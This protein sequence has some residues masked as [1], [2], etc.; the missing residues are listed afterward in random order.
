MRIMQSE[1]FATDIHMHYR[2]SETAPHIRALYTRE[3]SPQIYIIIAVR[4]EYV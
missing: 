4:L 2:Q 1:N 3:I